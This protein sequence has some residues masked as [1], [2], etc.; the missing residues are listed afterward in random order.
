LLSLQY[1][2]TK[3]AIPSGVVA[4]HPVAAETFHS[5]SE[6]MASVHFVVNEGMGSGDGSEAASSDVIVVASSLPARVR[7][8]RHLHLRH[9]HRH[10]PCP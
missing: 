1:F 7:P 4:Y 8:Y 6:A 3:A 10:L 2:W 9:H 5:A